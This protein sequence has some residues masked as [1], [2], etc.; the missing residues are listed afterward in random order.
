[1][2]S[3]WVEGVRVPG[4]MGVYE[5]LFKIEKGIGKYFGT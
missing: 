3:T 2:V 4:V 5:Y 1:M